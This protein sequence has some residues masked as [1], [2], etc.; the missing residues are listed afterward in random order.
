MANPYVYREPLKG[1]R[2]FYNRLSELNRVASRIAADRPQSVS[3]VGGPR[4][5]KTSLLNYLR[6]PAQQAQ[7]LGEPSGYVFVCL[8]LKEERPDNPEAFFSQVQADLR[9][10]GQGDLTPSYSG[11]SELV[12]QLMQEGRKLV[13][14]CDDF[15]QVTLHRGFPV[16]FFSFMRSIANSNDVGM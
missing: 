1:Q 12:K 9:R 3:V 2:G 16:D 14:F 7:Y 5:G 10:S 6:D 8:Y 15:D 11:F 13:V 4:T